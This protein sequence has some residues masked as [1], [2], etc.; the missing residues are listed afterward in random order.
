MNAVEDSRLED[1]YIAVSNDL[2]DE[3]H[4]LIDLVRTQLGPKAS[5]L[6]YVSSIQSLKSQ[7]RN[8]G[9]L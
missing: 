7:L 2:H 5:I 3:F 8:M 1:Q 4:S 6:V 9:V